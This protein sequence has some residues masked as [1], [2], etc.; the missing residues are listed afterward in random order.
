MHHTTRYE[1]TNFQFVTSYTSENRSR[2]SEVLTQ[3]L[4]AGCMAVQLSWEGCSDLEIYN[5]ACYVR[6]LTNKYGAEMVVNNRLDIAISVN[7]DALHVGQGD[8]PYQMARKLLPPSIKLGLTLDNYTQFDNQDVDYFG[9]G[10]VFKTTTKYQDTNLIGL[11]GIS[12]IREL[13]DKPLVVI[14]GITS[15]NTEDCVKAGAT[16]VAILGELY[17][18][19]DIDSTV[20]KV[21]S[22][23]K[24]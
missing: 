4:E 15:S 14:G 6:E 24:P 7:A 1:M 20:S 21:L 10:P 5:T 8:L 17:R 3:V 13:T 23:L 19:E 16:G 18:S 22:N 2:L 9:I 12:K 11:D